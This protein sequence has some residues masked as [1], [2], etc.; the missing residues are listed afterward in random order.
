MQ[1]DWLHRIL[2]TKRAPFA[3]NIIVVRHN[4]QDMPENEL[5]VID[6]HFV[7]SSTVFIVWD[8]M[9]LERSAW[10]YVTSI[11]HISVTIVTE[12]LYEFLHESRIPLS[13]ISR[14]SP[15]RT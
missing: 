13:R 8:D 9:W 4:Y 10:E 6:I 14:S 1:S 7:V 11:T 15:Y 3:L 5:T 12:Q 2:V